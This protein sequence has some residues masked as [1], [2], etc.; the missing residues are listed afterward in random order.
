MFVHC[1]H[2]RYSNAVPVGHAAID[3]VD[4]RGLYQQTYTSMDD[5][6]FAELTAIGSG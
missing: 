5:I 3:L 1:V 6:I 4:T 2:L